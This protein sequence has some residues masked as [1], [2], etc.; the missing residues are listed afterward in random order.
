MTDTPGSRAVALVLLPLGLLAQPG[1][2][3][4]LS[5]VAVDSSPS[6]NVYTAAGPGLLRSTDNGITFRPVFLRRAGQPQPLLNQLVID[7][8]N[9]R[10]LWAATEL[11]EGGVWKSTDGGE[12]W[13]IVNAGLPAGGGSV[14]SLHL[15]TGAP[16]TMYARVG[17]QLFKSVNGGERWELRGNLPQ[18]ITAFAI[19]PSNPNF[20]FAAQGAAVYINTAEGASGVWRVALNNIPIGAGVQVWSLAVDPRNPQNVL[21]AASGLT[22]SGSGVY[23][24]TNGG[25]A[26]TAVAIGSRPV[27]IVWD[28][29]GGDVVYCTALEN[30]AVY[31]SFNRGR[32]WGRVSI[33]ANAGL[34]L[35]AFDPKNP[36][37]LWAATSAGLYMTTEAITPQPRAPAWAAKFGQVRPTLAAPPVEYDFALERGQQG[38]L[39]LPIRV[40]ET[41]R[42]TLPVAVSTSGQP[43]LSITGVTGSTPATI[44]VSVD[45]QN[46]TAG[47]HTASIRVQSPQAANALL[48]VTVRA[49]VR[50]PAGDAPHLIHTYAGNGTRGNFGDNLP[51]NLAAIG[52]T[53]S[54]ALDAEGNLFLSDTS[55]NVIRRIAAATGIITRTAGSGQAGNGGDGGN[56]TVASL[57][58]PRGMAVNPSQHLLVVDSDNRRLRLVIPGGDIFPVANLPAGSR[59]LA[60]D[61]SGNR[62][63]AVPGLHRVVRV[64]PSGQVESFAGTG[65][66]GFRGDDQEARFARLSAPQDVAV[67]AAGNVYIADTENHRIRRVGADGKIRTV[68]GHGV[69]GF[70][71]DGALATTVALNRP[72]GMALDD[73]GN[74]YVADT[75]NQLVRVV[76]T[77]GSVRTL[78]GNGRPGSSG[79]GAAATSAQLRGPSDI[80]VDRDGNLFIADSLNF[81]IRRLSP[82]PKPVVPEIGEGSLRNFADDSTRLAPGALFTL[83]GVNLSTG[84]PLNAE[85]PWPTRLGDTTVLVNGKPA[86]LTLVSPA[87]INGQLPYDVEPGEATVR[88]VFKDQTSR[89]VRFLLS[90]VA[91]A[92]LVAGGRVLAQNADGAMIT[93]EN[94]ALPDSEVRL[95]FTGYGTVDPPV[96]TGAAGDPASK[97]VA[98]VAVRLGEADLEVMQ[99]SLASSMAGVAEVRVKLPADL[100]AGEYAVTIAMN[101]ETSNAATLPVGSLQ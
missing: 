8:A 55:H 81:R 40:L 44:L 59:G 68:A 56:A 33:A 83:T 15:T 7:P 99:V 53:D 88:V 13:T 91:P 20:M 30:G 96:S 100:A 36:D 49:T 28:P 31:R 71:G 12:N 14:D 92:I 70:Q 52:N 97:P 1:L 87:R 65:V 89:D 57:Q 61:G 101:G 66:A 23:M 85:V 6:A 93:A 9:P 79:D 34:Q 82:P 47:S 67:D 80:A 21:L 19:A 50:V 84:L 48:E 98:G 22:G 63:V 54:L 74:L 77:D 18:A 27:E 73:A 37:N 10:V 90:P 64:T 24:S 46:L 25:D 45:T 95:L 3:V 16:M 62:Y 41:S 35:L 78:A 43:W 86:A 60:L 76:R 11:E 4:P 32:S 5:L 58:S 26:F 72:G 38:R 69:A 94:P 39:E 2:N 75:D 17:T 51:A 42:W 29:N